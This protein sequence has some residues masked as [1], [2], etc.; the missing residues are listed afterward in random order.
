[1]DLDLKN[2]NPE[3]KLLKG[4][5]ILISGATSG[6][7]R[8]AALTFARYGAN[9]I[10]LGKKR[11][12]LEELYDLILQ[13]KY[14]EPSL[15]LM[16]FEFSRNEDYSNMHDALQLNYGH[17]DGLVNNAAILGEKKS[18]SQYSFNTWQKVI[19]INLD[20]VFYLTQSLI[21]LLNLSE[22]GS[23]IFTSSGLGQKG[24]AYWGAYSVSKLAIE[25]LMQILANELENTSKIRVNSI[26]PGPTRTKFRS[27]AFPAENPNKITKPKD[28]MKL[29]LFLMSNNSLHYNGVSINAQMT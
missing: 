12:K 8:E 10:L 26:N 9:T 20:S 29:Y 18:I 6:I 23:I 7:G 14:A 5:N 27:K 28:I 1:M 22:N 21:P 16:D 3:S 11:E 17:L 2:F 25:G 15:H 24:K 19:R 13:N 4:K